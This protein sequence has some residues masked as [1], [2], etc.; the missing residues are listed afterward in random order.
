MQALKEPVTLENFDYQ[1]AFTFLHLSDELWL[2]ITVA[3]LI[4]L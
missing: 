3:L 4:L 1:E 2:I